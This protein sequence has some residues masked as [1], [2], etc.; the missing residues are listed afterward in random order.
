[1][2]PPRQNGEAAVPGE[3]SVAEL[4][5]RESEMSMEGSGSRLPRQRAGWI[6]YALLLLL[7]M[8]W[9]S[10][11]MFTKLAVVTIP[12]VTLAAT[13][14]SFAALTLLAAA[15]YFGQALPRGFAIW[16]WIIPGALLGNAIPFTLISWGQQTIDAGLAAI[17]MGGMP[18]ITIVLAHFF[19]EDEKVTIPKVIGVMFGMVGLLIL[20]GPSKIMALGDDT[21]R[22]LA[23]LLAA[24]CY[25]ITTLITK[26]LTGLPRYST[27]AAIS[28]V[29]AVIMVPAALVYDQPWTL[30]PTGTA[31]IS[32]VLLG[33]LHTAFATLLMFK[34][35]M[36][37]GASFF[38][39]I[40]F[41]IPLTGVAWGVI[42][43]SE[44]L[45]QTQLIAMTI[46]LTGVL[47][48][49]GLPKR[50]PAH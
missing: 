21:I 37:Q 20:I 15:F 3:A 4:A 41:L 40:N 14:L 17:L 23:I 31:L 16:R 2:T 6:D 47:V 45:Q 33:V 30:A 22:Q 25:A 12:P 50:A 11:F 13:R 46:I 49:R 10:S 48:S 9:G 29:S 26:R 19:T 43:L 7:A 24:S 18:L 27:T 5:R 35:V 36:R 44:R 42:F 1:M 38:G 28:L 39:Q 8:I 34:L 32:S